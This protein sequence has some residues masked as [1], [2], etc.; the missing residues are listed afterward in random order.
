MPHEELVAKMAQPEYYYPGL[1]GSLESLEW[2]WDTGFAAV[3]GDN[4]GFEAWCKSRSIVLIHTVQNLTSDS[5]RTWRIKGAIPN[6][7]NNPFGIW[8]TD[9]RAV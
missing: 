1:D 2:L 7:R 5:C 6:A 9:R 4:P 8:A 3:A